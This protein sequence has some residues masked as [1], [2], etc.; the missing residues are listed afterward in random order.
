MYSAQKPLRPAIAAMGDFFA[1]AYSPDRNLSVGTIFVPSK[2]GLNVFLIFMGIF[3]FHT[4]KMESGCNTFAP[5]YASSR[6]SLYVSTSIT[7]ACGTILGSQVIKPSTSVK[8]S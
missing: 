4:G 2:S 8:F 1:R 3:A 5:I 6:S 7:V